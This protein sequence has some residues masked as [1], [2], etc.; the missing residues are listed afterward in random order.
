LLSQLGEIN[1]S[2]PTEQ[3]PW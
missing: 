2:F 1:H 3:F